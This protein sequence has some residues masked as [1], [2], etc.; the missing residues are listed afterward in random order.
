MLFTNPIL[1]LS[2]LATFSTALPTTTDP[3]LPSRTTPS[4]ETHTIIAGR[5]GLRFDPEVIVAPIGSIL[6]FH[7]LPANHS[8]VQSSFSKPCQTL[9]ATSFYSGFFPVS[10]NPDGSVAQNPEVFQ[11]EVKDAEPIWFY[12]AQNGAGGHCKGG[13]V[14]VVNQRVESGKT[15][16]EFRKLAAGFEGPAGVQGSVQGGWRGKNPNPNGGF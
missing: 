8:V 10:K 12:C 15:L 11:V 6:E 13:M 9:S 1:L 2:T 5:P 4:R 14:G 3:N 16:G 7:F